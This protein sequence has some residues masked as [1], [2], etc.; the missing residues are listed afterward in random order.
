MLTIVAFK[1]GFIFLS[2]D[3]QIR[4]NTKKRATGEPTALFG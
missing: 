3:A 2:K 4:Q 1:Q